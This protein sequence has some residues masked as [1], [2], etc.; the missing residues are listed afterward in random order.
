MVKYLIAVNCRCW[1]LQGTTKLYLFA[2]I[3]TLADIYSSLRG[4]LESLEG[5]QSCISEQSNAQSAGSGCMKTAQ[6]HP[7]PAFD[8]DFTSL[9]KISKNLRKLERSTWEFHSDTEH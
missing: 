1:N 3:L 8:A 5:V 4:H 7:K 2:Y 9:R 6:F